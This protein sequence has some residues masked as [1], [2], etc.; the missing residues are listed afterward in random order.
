MHRC[1]HPVSHQQCRPTAWSWQR[2][3]QR[4]CGRFRAYRAAVYLHKTTFHGDNRVGTV[5]R[6]TTLSGLYQ[7]L[8]ATY[9][10][11]DKCLINRDI[12][13]EKGNG[14]KQIQRDT[15]FS[16][17]LF[18]PVVGRDDSQKERTNLPFVP[19]TFTGI[20]SHDFHPSVSRS[21]RTILEPLW[22]LLFNGL[23]YDHQHRNSK[24]TYVC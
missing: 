13:P 14:H 21:R 12:Y 11:Y 23:I 10:I 22:V 20:H 15:M 5:I 2:R 19:G 8:A 7:A 18:F 9:S 3:V 4:Q 1:V 17:K 24:T 6:G 16:L